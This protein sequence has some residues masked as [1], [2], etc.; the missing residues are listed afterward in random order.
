MSPRMRTLTGVAVVLGLAV[1]TLL[2][3]LI[4]E[5]GR[6]SEQIKYLDSA[7]T[8]RD[9]AIAALASGDSQLRAQVTSLGGTPKVPSPQVVISGI[10]GAAG[11]QGLP[12][13]NGSPGV[14]GSAGPVG[15]PGAPGPSG[16]PGSPGMAGPSGPAGPQGVAGPQGEPGQQ[17]VQ[18]DQ[19]IQGS[20]GPNCPD[21]YSLQPEVINGHDALVCEQPP[22]PTVS[23]S[24][25]AQSANPT[26]AAAPGRSPSPAATQGAVSP[27]DA[28]T[29]TVASASAPAPV[30]PSTP[31]PRSALWPL[32]VFPLP[33][34]H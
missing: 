17:G 21:G 23:P 29:L 31:A 30:P 10:A 20:P 33:R 4:L 5:L 14:A 16:A 12:G 27:A 24:A 1:V 15:S 8:A 2:I 34:R 7:S 18:G 13:V 3:F 19:G 22:S 11:A 9:R 32:E 25:G 6:A 26:G 28:A